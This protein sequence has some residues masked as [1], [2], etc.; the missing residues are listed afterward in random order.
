MSEIN[1]P[2]PK[3]NALPVAL[4]V[5]ALVGWGTAGYVY[6]TDQQR[7]RVL[8]DQL[9]E[10]VKAEGTLTDL[11]QKVSS[12]QAAL[13]KA[14]HDLE[15]AGQQQKTLQAQSEQTRSQLADLSGQRDTTQ[16]ALQ[17]AQ[18]GLDDAQKQMQALQ[19]QQRGQCE[20]GAGGRR[21]SR[22]DA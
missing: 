8:S 22:A 6:T 7:Q 12:Q 19:Q 10:H 16:K 11:N 18:Q 15:E 21:A 20:A 2:K 3:S 4:G 14:T 17:Q 13:G 1:P 9:A 5:V